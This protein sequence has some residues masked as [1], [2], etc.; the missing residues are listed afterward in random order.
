MT[1]QMRRN[2]SLTEMLGGALRDGGHALGAVP[3]LLKQLLTDGGWRAFVT[4]RGERV[5]HERF[6]EFVRTPPLKGLGASMDLVERIVGT[7][8]PELL[9]LLRT[10]RKRRPGKKSIGVEST[11][12]GKGEDASLA[13]SR[14]EHDAP[15]EYEAVRRG[16]KTIHKAAVAA[17]IRRPRVSVRT[18]DAA[19]AA[20]TLRKHMEPAQVAELARL[21]AEVGTP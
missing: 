7:D 9:V 1:D 21:L 15:E 20:R 12:I 16:E 13:A 19:S 8:D 3:G 5:E 6:D 17:G 2:G 14:L 4:Q 11:P 18:D 10:A